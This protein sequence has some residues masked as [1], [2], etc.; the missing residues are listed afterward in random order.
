MIA[1]LSGTVARI[2]AAYIVVDVQGVGYK[3]FVPVTVI[4]SLPPLGSPVTLVTHMLVREDDLSL[5]G[6]EGDLDLRLFELLLTVSGVGPKAALALLSAL[7]AQSLANSIAQDDIRTLTRVPGI[8]AKTAQRMVL[9]LKDKLSQIGLEIQTGL[10][11]VDGTMKAPKLT[12][13]DDVVS[14]LVNLGYNKAEA[15]RAVDS[16]LPTLEGEPEFK[17]LLRAGLNRLTNAK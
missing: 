13:A 5:Y 3:V 9:E 4:E 14:A 7:P 16:A 12:L 8:G 17:I 11:S 6:F 10:L 15:Q 1:Q 2:A